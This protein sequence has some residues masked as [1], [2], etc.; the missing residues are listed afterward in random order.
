MVC[1]ELPSN[2]SPKPTLESVVAHRGE[3]NGSV[4]WL[5]RCEKSDEMGFNIIGSIG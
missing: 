2:Q 1:Q 4:A 3:F 5:N